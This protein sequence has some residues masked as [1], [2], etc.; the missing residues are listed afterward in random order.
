MNKQKFINTLEKRLVGL[1]QKDIDDR[2]SFY[3]EMI[4]DYM[5]EGLSEKDAISKIGSI[6]E[7]VSQLVADTPLTKI[8]KER[9]QPKR[10]LSALEIILLVLGSPI[11]LS[12]F[13]TV[14][15]VILSIYAAF[16]SMIIALWASFAAFAVCAFAGVAGIILY[17]C[18]GRLLAGIAILGGGIACA[19]F[20][21]LMF[22]V[23]KFATKGVLRLTKMII[24]GIK[25]SILKRR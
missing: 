11:W 19:G 5:E 12:V 3:S 15:A 9:I 2:I 7:V 24:L 17:A 21:I 18:E 16:W 8:V 25:S 20:A 23:C 6:E 10:K 14:F 1:P 22:F 13:I 4:D